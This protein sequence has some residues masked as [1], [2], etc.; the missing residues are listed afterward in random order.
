MF[1][2][3]TKDMKQTHT[4]LIPTMI[5]PHFRFMQGVL[6]ADGYKSIL[7]SENRQN[8]VEEGL[9]SVHN[10]MCYPAIVVI[11]QL[12]SALKDGLC[13]PDHTSI[14]LFQTCGACRATNYLSVLRQALKHAGFPQVPVFAIHG[15]KE[16]TDSF[17]MGRGMLVDAIKAAVYGDTLMNVRNRMMPYEI[18]KGS[19]KALFDKW[20]E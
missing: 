12:I 20:M 11:G 4:I 18:T 5:D 16:E 13:D 15:L 3:F 14:M 17:H 10:D 1:A 6:A 19:T 9:K 2:K 8:I 7:L